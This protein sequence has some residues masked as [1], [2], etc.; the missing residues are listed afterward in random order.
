MMSIVGDCDSL[1]SSIFQNDL[2]SR[3]SKS[4]MVAPL[5]GS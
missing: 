1:F 5:N 3:V 4:W 2:D